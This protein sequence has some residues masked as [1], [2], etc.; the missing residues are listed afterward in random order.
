MPVILSAYIAILMHGG[1][2][3]P[4]K[5]ALPAVIFTNEEQVYFEQEAGREPP[6]WTGIAIISTRETPDG[7]RHDFKQVDAFGVEQTPVEGLSEISGAAD[8]DQMELKLGGQTIK[9][10]RARPVTCWTAIPRETRKADGSTDWF[11]AQNIKI[12]D[13]GGRAIIGKDMP[14][15]KPVVIRMRNVVWPTG[16]NRPSLVLYIHS[17]DEPDKAVSYAWANPDAARIGIN[18]R[19]MQASCTVDG[20]D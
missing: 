18:L 13:Q 16:N 19:W 9:L 10:R 8:G 6:P 4:D 7:V 20:K 12:H 5:A 11:F 14:G 1:S 2:A 17:P 15:V 3:S